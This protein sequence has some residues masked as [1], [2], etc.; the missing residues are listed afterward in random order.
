MIRVDAEVF[1]QIRTL[2]K[3][4]TLKQE[5]V[6]EELAAVSNDPKRLSPPRRRSFCECGMTLRLI[7]DLE[8]QIFAGA[9]DDVAGTIGHLIAFLKEVQT[10]ALPGNATPVHGSP[11]TGPPLLT[12]P[13]PPVRPI[14]AKGSASR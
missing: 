2:R 14:P 12:T 1:I 9:I 6:R 13:R 5:R 8:A 3:E 11:P 7:D 4:L 10:A